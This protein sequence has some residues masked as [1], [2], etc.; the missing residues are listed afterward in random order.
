[1]KSRQI[2][3]DSNYSR[4]VLLLVDARGGEVVLLTVGPLHVVDVW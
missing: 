3:A 1:M 4:P 2:P